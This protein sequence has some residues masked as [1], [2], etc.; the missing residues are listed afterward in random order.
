[1][2]SAKKSILIL[3]G[4]I[5]GLRVAQRLQKRLPS[6]Y[7]LVLVDRSLVHVFNADLYQVATAFI[8]SEK[9]ATE[10]Q[11]KETVATPLPQLIDPWKVRFIQ[12]EVVDLQIPEKKVLLSN[13]STLRYEILVLALGSVNHDFNVPGVKEHAY[14]LKTVN[15]ALQI[16]EQMERL[17]KAA[18]KK[19]TLQITIA[20]G[21]ATGVEVAGELTGTLHKLA[22]KHQ[23]DSDRLRI[24]L[25]QSGGSLA[26]FGDKGTRLIREELERRG[27]ELWMG[28]RVT[29]LEEKKL[30]LL[31]SKQGKTE[32]LDNDLLIW[33][34][35]VKVN[36]VVARHFGERGVE[37]NQSLQSREH[38]NVF[39]LGDCARIRT[40][41]YSHDYVP[42]MAQYALKQG[43]L[44]AKNI[45]RR[46]K[47]RPLLDYK[48]GT[49]LYVVPI[50]SRLTLFQC[51][52]W[53]FSNFFTR[54]LKPIITLKYALGIM[55]P[56]RAWQKFR[57][58]EEI[59]EWNDE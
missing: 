6:S 33:T 36:P 23:H 35:G 42:W 56:R 39:A 19:E 7:E 52:S 47:R 9:K 51:G 50:G 16:H 41:V 8:Q 31:N 40:Q 5:A 53:L 3:G 26:G 57:L 2:V 29:K 43:D 24:R 27:V 38:S 45:L 46:I 54:L 12:A 28:H 37:V 58:G 21:G 17:F 1:M 13:G 59:W 34:C 10:A 30:T 18:R 44:V 22:R 32:V 49:P 14:P 11:L 48:M 4:G 15:D 25:I 20:G 55:P